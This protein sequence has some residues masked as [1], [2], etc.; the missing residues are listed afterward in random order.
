MAKTQPKIIIVV[1]LLLVVTSLILIT[2]DVSAADW[3]KG[4]LH[5]HI[6]FSTEEGYDGIESGANGADDCSELLE[7][8][9]RV[10]ESGKNVSNLTQSALNKGLSWLS[11]TDHSYCLDENEFN[12]VKNE[13]NTEDS[14]RSDVTCVSGVELSVKGGLI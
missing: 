8:L 14:A 12:V 3:Y 1:M 13:C 4:S 11:F 6:G 5:Q 2:V 10:I 7:G 9:P